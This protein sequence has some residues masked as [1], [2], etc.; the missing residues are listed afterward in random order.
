MGK[1]GGRIWSGSENSHHSNVNPNTPAPTVSI[2]T[3]EDEYSTYPAQA[4]DSPVFWAFFTHFSRTV[5]GVSSRFSLHSS[6]AGL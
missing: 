5:S 6:A 3:V 4:R 1:R 2:I